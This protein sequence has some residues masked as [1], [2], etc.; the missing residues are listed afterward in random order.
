MRFLALTIGLI[1]T[2][3]SMPASA[4]IIYDTINGT[5]ESGFRTRIS[6]PG[7][8]QNLTGLTQVAN[9]GPLGVSFVLGTQTNITQATLRLTATTPTDGGSVLVYIVPDSAGLPTYTGTGASFAFTGATLLG[10]ILDSSLSSSSLTNS[11]VNT[12]VTLAAGNYWLAAVASASSFGSPNNSLSTARWA[13]TNDFA[14]TGGIVG[15]QTPKDFAQFATPQAVTASLII[16]G[17]RIDGLFMAQIQGD[18]VPEPATLAL[19]GVG[20]M[21]MGLA[22]RHR[23]KTKAQG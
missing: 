4:A 14:G 19:L 6:A 21:G 7:T 20:L 10:T 17:S 18:A 5:T 16:G 3:A 1:A 8:P 12:N 13:T 23:N 22:C 9:G 11:V 2:A 15:A